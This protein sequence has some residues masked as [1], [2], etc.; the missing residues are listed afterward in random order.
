MTKDRKIHA[1]VLSVPQ[2]D[3]KL[4][5]SQISRF[6]TLYLPPGFQNILSFSSVLAVAYDTSKCVP[7][8][9]DRAP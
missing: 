6:V 8:S 2:P 3:V 1:T 5:C 4:L 9:I 7:Y